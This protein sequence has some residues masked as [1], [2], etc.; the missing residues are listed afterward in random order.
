MVK[1]SSQLYSILFLAA[2]SILTVIIVQT[3]YSFIKNEMEMSKFVVSIIM[4]V[5]FVFII[6]KVYDEIGCKW[7]NMK[8]I[9]VGKKK[10][11]QV[12]QTVQNNYYYGTSPK[13]NV[14]KFCPNCGMS[15]IKQTLVSKLEK[16]ETLPR[17][18][19]NCGSVI[20]VTE[21]ETGR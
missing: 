12:Q 21:I 3:I 1:F 15:I 10:K 8:I 20:N 17:Y 11:D 7:E 9:A 16:N 13:L 14:S 5:V 2:M 4:E 18:C 19:R 6:V